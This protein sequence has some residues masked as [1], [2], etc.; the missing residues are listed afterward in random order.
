MPNEVRMYVNV[1]T[2]IRLILVGVCEN[3]S[4]MCF[5]QGTLPSLKT[6]CQAPKSLKPEHE[7]LEPTY[8]A[9]LSLIN[10]L[11]S[12]W[13]L[14]KHVVVI[15]IPSKTGVKWISVCLPAKQS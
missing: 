15:H 2:W 13:M 1:R 9:A 11:T 7:D 4:F 6:P 3:L 10:K 14:L 12:V 8:D 5:V